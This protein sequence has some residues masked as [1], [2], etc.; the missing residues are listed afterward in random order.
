MLEEWLL[1]HHI[2]HISCHLH[3]QLHRHQHIHINKVWLSLEAEYLVKPFRSYIW[4]CPTLWFSCVPM[5]FLIF[6]PFQSNFSATHILPS[7]Y[8]F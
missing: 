6:N 1:Q 8:L 7:S 3:Q 5:L 2:R 4:P